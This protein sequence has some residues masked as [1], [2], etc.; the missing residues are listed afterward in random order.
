MGEYLEIIKMGHDLKNLIIW[1]TVKKILAWNKEDN[2]YIIFKYLNVLY[3]EKKS[4]NLFGDLKACLKFGLQI[5]SS[6]YFQW[7][8]VC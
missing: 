8:Y 2:M 1:E 5:E 6:F 4:L 3:M 7:F